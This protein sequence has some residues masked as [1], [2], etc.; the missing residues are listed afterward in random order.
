MQVFTRPM[1]NVAV[2]AIQGRLDVN[3]CEQLK[4][5]WASQEAAEF[6]IIDLSQ[7]EFIDSMGLAVLVSRLK[8]VR[9]S[10]GDLL[11]VRPSE[12]VRIVLDLTAMIHVFRIYTSVDEALAALGKS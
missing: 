3:T 6:L 5:A 1:G 11:L 2:L 7:T 4:S 9:A 12:A 8:A 10:G